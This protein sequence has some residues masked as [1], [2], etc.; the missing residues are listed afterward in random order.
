M[1]YTPQ[2]ERLCGAAARSCASKK[3]ASELA[4]APVEKLLSALRKAVGK[5]HLSV[6]EHASFTFSLEGIS[7]ACSHQLVRHRIASYSQQSQRHVKLGRGGY[8]V[9]PSISRNPE[10][11][12]AFKKA[13]DAAM[14][15]YERLLELGV[16]LEDARYLLPNAAPTNIVVTMNARELLHFFELRC[17]THAQ[18]EIREV[19][20]EMLRKVKEVAPELF[21]RAGPACVSKGVCP[22]NDPSCPLYERNVK[23]KETFLKF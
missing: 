6:V 5:G 11:L 14:E 10:A 4:G 8:V 12:D 23:F 20:W 2:P 9:P 13:L 15:G 16:P 19:A 3:G 7:R 21:G 22:E 17:C 1:A 18:W